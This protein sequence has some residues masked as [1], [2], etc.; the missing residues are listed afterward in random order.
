MELV[1]KINKKLH[2]LSIISKLTNRKL[3]RK[4]TKDKKYDFCNEL[5][6]IHFRVKSI[7]HTKW[8]FYFK[9][10]WNNVSKEDKYSYG[11]TKK[12]KLKR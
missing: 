3:K 2:F 10:C 9:K 11:G 7:N 6:E 4:L 8:V 5:D 1:A 12:S